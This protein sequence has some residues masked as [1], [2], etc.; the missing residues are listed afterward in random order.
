MNKDHTLV[1]L[2]GPKLWSI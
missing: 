1:K 2:P